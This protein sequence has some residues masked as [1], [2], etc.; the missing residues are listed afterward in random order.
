MAPQ[1]DTGDKTT[2][3]RVVERAVALVG[4]VVLVLVVW[5]VVAN[6]VSELDSAKEDT[7]EETVEETKKKGPRTYTVKEGDNF[8]I[9]AEETGVPVDTLIELNPDVDART[10]PP[11]YELRLR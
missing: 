1:Q 7:T 3:S 4:L 2:T 11:G 5:V 9:I 10:L 8:E 6:G